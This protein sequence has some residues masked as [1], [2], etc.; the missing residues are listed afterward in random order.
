MLSINCKG[1]KARKH[2][3]TQG[4]QNDQKGEEG[5]RREPEERKRKYRKEKT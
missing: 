3:N 2:V 1:Y 4:K 5:N